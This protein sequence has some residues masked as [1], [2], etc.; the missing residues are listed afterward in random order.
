MMRTFKPCVKSWGI[1]KLFCELM[2]IFWFL[3]PYKPTG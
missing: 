2:K 1:M 3:K